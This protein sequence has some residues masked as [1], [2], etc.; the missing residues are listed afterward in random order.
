M[1][2]LLST[3]RFV[4]PVSLLIAFIAFHFIYLHMSWK[5]KRGAKPSEIISEADF[6]SLSI[7][8]CGKYPDPKIAM[9]TGIYNEVTGLEIN[10]GHCIKILSYEYYKNFPPPKENIRIEQLVEYTHNRNAPL[11]CVSFSALVSENYSGLFAIL[12]EHLRDSSLIQMSHYG[13]LPQYSTV[14]DYF[15]DIVLQKRP[16]SEPPLLSALQSA[17]LDS[18]MIWDDRIGLDYQDS[19]FSKLRPRHELHERVKLLVKK[20]KIGTACVALARYQDR[21]DISVLLDRLHNEPTPRSVEAIRF[22]PCEA[23]Y[24]EL[25]SGFNKAKTIELPAPG[26]LR[27]Y[28]LALSKYPKLETVAL[29]RNALKAKDEPWQDEIRWFIYLAIRKYPHPIYSPLLKEVKLSKEDF[30]FLNQELPEIDW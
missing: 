14:G 30:E 27:E 17:E 22:F 16:D 26:L 4:F 6:V 12:K 18:L 10:G 20:R 28:V 5:I 24:D 25:V 19:L 3:R 21:S 1:K 15:M 23:F 11:R 13:C 9:S 29:F 2:S 8:K 7:V